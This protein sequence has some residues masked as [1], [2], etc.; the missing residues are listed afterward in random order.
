[1][2]NQADHIIRWLRSESKNNID[3]KKLGYCDIK[4]SWIRFIDGPTF[5]KV[6][7]TR[8]I[9]GDL[10]QISWLDTEVI[11]YV[12]QRHAYDG[13]LGINDFYGDPNHVVTLGNWAK[14][15]R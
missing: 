5:Y 11:A 1:M 12:D 15:N 14:A 7:Y 13:L 4:N 9:R 2:S 8:Q 10:I 3:R 6:K